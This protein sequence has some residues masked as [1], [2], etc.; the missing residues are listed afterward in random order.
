MERLGG[1][2]VGFPGE[3]VHTESPGGLADLRF[4]SELWAW[5]VWVAGPRPRVECE[6]ESAHS[7]L[8]VNT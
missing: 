2:Q 7:C 8:P 6:L 3:L 5:P 4:S 1:W